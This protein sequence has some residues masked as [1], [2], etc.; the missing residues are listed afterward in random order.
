[1]AIPA[2]SGL[3]LH[4]ARERR[5]LELLGQQ[6]ILFGGQKIGEIDLFLLALLTTGLA[7]GELLLGLRLVLALGLTFD[8]LGRLDDLLTKSEL[9]ILTALERGEEAV[10]DLAERELAGLVVIGREG[11]RLKRRLT[12]VGQIDLTR[13][14]EK[15]AKA[16]A[17]AAFARALASSITR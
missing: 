6:G 12:I 3:H 13:V 2:I 7:V 8:A 5:A 1:L 14:R 17:S 15:A 11:V 10:D 9:S 4:L 16:A